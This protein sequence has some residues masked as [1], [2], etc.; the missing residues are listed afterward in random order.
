M[1]KSLLL[2]VFMNRRYDLFQL[3]RKVVQ[4]ISA[5]EPTREFTLALIAAGEEMLAEI[6]GQAENQSGKALSN[7]A[8]LTDVPS[9]KA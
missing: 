5:G 9:K 8:L 2:G 3:Y 1:E 7:E 4:H 6:D